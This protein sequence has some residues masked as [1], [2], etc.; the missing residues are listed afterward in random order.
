MPVI[1]NPLTPASQIVLKNSL[2]EILDN[3]GIPEASLPTTLP[4]YMKLKDKLVLTHPSVSIISP[5][6]EGKTVLPKITLSEIPF[7]SS[8]KDQAC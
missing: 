7:L 4:H 5:I 6:I 2:K 3:F 8:K 1:L